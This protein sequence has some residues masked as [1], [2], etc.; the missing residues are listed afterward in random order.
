M[1]EALGLPPVMQEAEVAARELGRIRAKSLASIIA[2]LV[3]ANE[4]MLKAQADGETVTVSER[5]GGAVMRVTID[6]GVVP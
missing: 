1:L 3:N 4:P 2:D 5:G 6:G